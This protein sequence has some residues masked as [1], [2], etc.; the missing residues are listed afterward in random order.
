VQLTYELILTEIFKGAVPWLFGECQFVLTIVIYVNKLIIEYNHQ[1]HNT[2]R[3]AKVYY[4][5]KNMC[6]HWLESG[7]KKKKTL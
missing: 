7:N 1:K 2:C 4:K 6:K 3:T 5:H